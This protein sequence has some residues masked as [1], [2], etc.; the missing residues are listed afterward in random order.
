MIRI[1]DKFLPED[2]FGA[3]LEEHIPWRYG[4]KSNSQT[5]PHGHWTHKPFHDKKLNLADLTP[6]LPKGIFLDAWKQVRD[7]HLPNNRLIRAYWNG[8]TYGTDGYFHTDSQRTG[9]TTALL[10]TVPTWDADWAGE[11]VVER[12]DGTCIAVI[13]RPNRLLLFP[14]EWRHCARAV[15][16]RCETIRVVMVL[17]NRRRGSMDYEALSEWL[18]EH[19]ALEL[20]HG[21]FSTLHDHLLRCYEA[22]EQKNLPLFVRRGAGLHSIY[23]TN[24]FRHKLVE[25]V[26][27]TRQIVRQTWGGEAE[28]LVA[29][30]AALDR[31][32]TLE[33]GGNMV[34]IQSGTQVSITPD[35]LLCLRLVEAA[36]L[37]DQGSLEKF[38]KIKAAWEACG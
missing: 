14:S 4:A 34:R 35:Q 11:T 29:A 26:A 32:K 31:P 7:V 33:D 12:P 8:Y 9:E 36:N 3:L 25:G 20:K 5:D 27:A 1:Y 16:R 21:K 13:P 17:K 18:V 38:P 24:S 2:L 30:F 28:A 10:Y 37:Q 6:Q 22:C 23:G 15:S 19:K